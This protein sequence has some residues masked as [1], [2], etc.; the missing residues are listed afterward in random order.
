MLP[1]VGAEGYPLGLLGC[2]D[3]VLA[4]LPG[5]LAVAFAGSKPY[6]QLTLR[7]QQGDALRKL[8]TSLLFGL[9]LVATAGTQQV[10]AQV[11]TYCFTNNAAYIIYMRMFSSNRSWQWPAGGGSW[12]LDDRQQHCLRLA[13]NVGE[14]IC[15]GG[16]DNAGR[17]WGVGMNNNVSCTA[18]C[19]T[20][21]TNADNWTYR[22]ELENE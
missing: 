8:I 18:C 21:G 15:F 16:S 2:G 19:G 6:L 4:S 17:N 9:V 13:C 10:Q 1:A 22:W 3:Q 5:F 14:Q 20:C 11:V 7:I 12:V